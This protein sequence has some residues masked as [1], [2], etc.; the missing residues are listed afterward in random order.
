MTCQK[1]VV[2]IF[3]IVTVFV[4]LFLIFNAL[5]GFTIYEQYH[6]NR[7]T[8]GLPWETSINEYAGDL[9]RIKIRF[10]KVIYFVGYGYVILCIELFDRPYRAFMVVSSLLLVALRLLLAIC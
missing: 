2:P 4:I 5:R 6:K 1:D 7:L 8:K 10:G 9:E 3:V